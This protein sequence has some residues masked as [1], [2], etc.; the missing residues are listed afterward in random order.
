MFFY[1]RYSYCDNYELWTNIKK[2][3]KLY[4]L[5]LKATVFKFFSQEQWGIF[6][7]AFCCFTNVK[8]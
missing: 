5:I 2:N 3:K 7:F 6:L 4:R 1:I 8:E